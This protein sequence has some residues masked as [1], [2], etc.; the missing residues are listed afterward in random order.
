MTSLT[1]KSEYSIDTSE[2]MQNASSSIND[3]QSP[4]KAKNDSF[5]NM[6]D[7][8]KR[9]NTETS[10]MKSVKKI[11]NKKLKY[12]D[13]ELSDNKSKY[14]SNINMKKTSNAFNKSKT[15]FNKK[16]NISPRIT[17]TTKSFKKE[18]NPLVSINSGKPVVI[19][20]IRRIVSDRLDNS[21]TEY[22]NN[23]DSNVIERET[24][25]VAIRSTSY[26]SSSY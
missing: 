22:K 11:E 9:I 25:S 4:N 3:K 13:L 6:I 18:P 26:N 15:S 19:N 24:T 5:E 21:I 2:I 14:I 20:N 1:L 16:P 23:F 17:K 7:G 10:K 12:S 8:F